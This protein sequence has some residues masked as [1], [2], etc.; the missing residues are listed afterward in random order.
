MRR[1]ASGFAL[2]VWKGLRKIRKSQAAEIILSSKFIK[3]R[4]VGYL[5]LDWTR[6]LV[7]TRLREI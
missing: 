4:V 1:G 5:Q 6:N 2:V 7:S 3:L